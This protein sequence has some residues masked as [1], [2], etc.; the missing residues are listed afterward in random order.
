MDHGVSLAVF[1][2]A[3]YDG[4]NRTTQTVNPTVIL[5]PDAVWILRYR[6]YTA[7]DGVRATRRRGSG[8]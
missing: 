1:V 7:C 2:L 8:E 6:T 3:M 4:Y 5:Q